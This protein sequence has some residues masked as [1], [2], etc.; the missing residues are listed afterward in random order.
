MSTTDGLVSVQTINEI[1]NL[2]IAGSYYFTA[3]HNYK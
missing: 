1:T 3:S 2:L